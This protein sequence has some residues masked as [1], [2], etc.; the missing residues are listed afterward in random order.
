MYIIK[1][2]LR[3]RAPCVVTL[4]PSA[5]IPLEAQDNHHARGGAELLTSNK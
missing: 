4:G 5:R 1:L 2:L 3:A